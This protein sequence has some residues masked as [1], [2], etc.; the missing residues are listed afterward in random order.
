MPDVKE[1][2]F[3][4]VPDTV[5][6]RDILYKPPLI[7][8]P[9]QVTLEDYRK[10]APK[11]LDQ[12]GDSGLG[13]CTGFALATVC[14][15]LL[16]RRGTDEDFVSSHMLYHMARKY[17]ASKASLVKG[18]SARSAIKG[19]QKHGV[20]SEAV[21]D[22]TVDKK[23]T[24]KSEDVITYHNV[25]KNNMKYIAED[26]ARRPLGTYL[27]VNHKDLNSMQTA[28]AD[29]NVLYATAIVHDG[30]DVEKNGTTG[31]FGEI[32]LVNQGDDNRGHAF[33]IVGYNDSGFWI[34]N[35]WGKDWGYDGFGHLSYTDWLKNGLDAWVVRLGVPTIEIDESEKTNITF[36]F[37]PIDSRPQ[38]NELRAHIIDIS[39]N[40]TGVKPF[41]ATKDD[42]DSI[43][44]EFINVANGNNWKRKAWEKKRLLLYAP[45]F[46]DDESLVSDQMN[47]LK[48]ILKF[49]AEIYPLTIIWRDEYWTELYNLLSRAK[50]ATHLGTDNGNGGIFDLSDNFLIDRYEYTADVFTTNLKGNREWQEMKKDTFRLKTTRVL[51][52]AISSRINEID[53]IHIVGHGAGAIFL[54]SLVQLLSLKKPVKI[55]PDNIVA[56]SYPKVEHFFETS[57]E[58]AANNDSITQT[59]NYKDPIRQPCDNKDFKVET[60][61]GKGCKIESCTLWA[62]ACTIE[63]FNSTFMEAI[64]AGRSDSYG[65]KKLNLFTLSE[66]AEEDD[67]FMHG[68]GKSFLYFI[69]NALE[70]ENK[71]Q[72]AEVGKILGMKKFIE[73]DETIKDLFSNGNNNLITTPNFPRSLNDNFQPLRTYSHDSFSND[74]SILNTTLDYI[75]G[76]DESKDQKKEY[77]WR[78]SG[79]RIMRRQLKKQT[80][81]PRHMGKSIRIGYPGHR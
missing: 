43:L 53:E 70:K 38:F 25:K 66:E 47:A 45:N 51:A 39:N 3:R 81:V 34:Q 31:R 50:L 40:I 13:K 63:L 23:S 55:I 21:W 18:A 41:S 57:K 19:W 74:M 28:I 60:V 12:R 58:T 14:N 64:N 20:S 37:E 1:E 75:M 15:Y 22:V 61:D 26:A 54:A 27:R 16:K 9:S 44:E 69:S 78:E 11:I 46:F 32:K 17:G 77:K 68:Y 10:K 59:V 30:W 36:P 67:G 56:N 71:P 8:L 33:V 5:D 24:A 76:D 7:D 29:D 35:S 52:D 80:S 73:N 65:I 2:M 72:G 62:P 4:A 48:D 79:E 49:D 42:I 6:F